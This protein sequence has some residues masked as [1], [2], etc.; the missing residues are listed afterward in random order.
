MRGP[1]I[2]IIVEV[3]TDAIPGWGDSPHYFVELIQSKLDASI[4]HYEPK[5][6]HDASYSETDK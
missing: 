3:N 1:R 6:F 5:V 4:P 2:R